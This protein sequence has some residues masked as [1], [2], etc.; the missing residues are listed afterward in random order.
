[1][2][3]TTVGSFILNEDPKSLA[4]TT[5][6]SQRLLRLFYKT[7]V[8]ILVMRQRS[9]PWVTKVIIMLLALALQVMLMSM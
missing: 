4:T 8:R 1:M 3:K 9:Q 2:M 5:K 6:G 7:W